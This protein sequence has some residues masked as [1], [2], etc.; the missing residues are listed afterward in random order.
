MSVLENNLMKYMNKIQKN[1]III[2]IDIYKYLTKI[3]HLF[4]I[5]VLSTP[6]IEVVPQPD[7]EY[8]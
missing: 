5:K 1:L 7:K 2:S 4:I 8:P 3:Q 6:R